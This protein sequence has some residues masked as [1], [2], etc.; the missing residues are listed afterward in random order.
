[1]HDIAMSRSA[2]QPGPAD[3]AEA[4]LHLRLGAIRERHP[5]ADPAMVAE[6]VRE[7]LAT[8][9]G[10]L[11]SPEIQLLAEIEELGRTIAR[12]RAEVAALG[13]DDITESHIPVASDELEA[14]VV[15]TASATDRI[16]AVCE[17]LDTLAEGLGARGGPTRAVAAQ[18]VREATTE[19]YEAC[20]FQD[21]TG[22]RIGKVV[23]ALQAIDVKVARI[24]EAFGER[25]R[26]PARPHPELPPADLLHGPQL[27]ELAM[28]QLDIDRLLASL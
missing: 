21:I 8:M 4:D 11:S 24:M 10:D 14:V 28:D 3:R 5:A 23:G 25:A 17:T 15:H 7:V 26:G 20:S 6:V 27:P 22:Q 1:M 12:A 13:V 18:A 16:L 2:A 9:R 19:V